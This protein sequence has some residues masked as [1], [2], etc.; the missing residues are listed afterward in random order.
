M[1]FI[2]LYQIKLA[3]HIKIIKKFNTSFSGIYQIKEI[4]KLKPIFFISS[5]KCHS[6]V[7]GTSL[8]QKLLGL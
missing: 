2:G 8:E 7:H 6:P 5:T 3:L 4:V 1:N